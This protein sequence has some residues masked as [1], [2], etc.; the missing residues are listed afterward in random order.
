MKAPTER[1]SDR[2]ENYA[3]YRPRYPDAMLQ[4][5]RE[6]V[7]Q[8]AV[9]A[10]VGSGTG[11]I[12][13]QLLDAEFEVYA[14]EPNEPMRSEAGRTLNANP[15]FHSVPGSAE[16]T[17]LANQSIDFIT[18][19]Q[20]FHWFDRGKAKVEF[21]RI[22]KPGKWVALIWNERQSEASTFDWK[23]EQ[24]LR[25]GAPDYG[26]VNHRN[27]IFED[28]RAFFEPGEVTLKK[29]SNSQKLG[30]PAFIGRLLSSSYVPLAG[31]PGHRE[32]LAAAER[33]F[34]ENAVDGAVSF[35]YETLL[36]LGAFET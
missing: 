12:T 32:I 8:P 5:I 9:V 35:A 19:A 36:Y 7:P 4:F 3:K 15:L 30:R 13:K 29:Y 17:T 1:F 14:I 6:I 34:D 11:I 20:S 25:R 22:L 28:I 16:A 24:L 18:S 31:E 27:V 21:R 26:A 33:L 23:Y 10:D 2:V